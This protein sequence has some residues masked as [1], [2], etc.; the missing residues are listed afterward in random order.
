MILMD[1]FSFFS[2]VRVFR[3]GFVI[4]PGFV[5][6]YFNNVLCY[7]FFSCGPCRPIVDIPYCTGLVSSAL[8]IQVLLYTNVWYLSLHLYTVLLC[9]CPNPTQTHNPQ[10]LPKPPPAPNKRPNFPIRQC[11][12]NERPKAKSKK[13]SQLN[14]HHG[15]C[16]I[17]Q[18]S[19]SDQSKMGRF[20]APS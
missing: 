2:F 18:K 17:F 11:Q 9:P 4:F 20:S 8:E 6:Y 3:R 1:F 19:K 13:S 12:K 10:N 7:S 14:N 5:Y 15:E 16:V